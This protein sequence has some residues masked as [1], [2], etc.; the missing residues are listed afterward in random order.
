MQKKIKKE[1]KYTWITLGVSIV[2]VLFVIGRN[3]LIDIPDPPADTISHIVATVLL[4]ITIGIDILLKSG[5][6]NQKFKSVKY[7]GY[8]TYLVILGLLLI[9]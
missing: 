7:I 4:I 5:A 2:A 1:K 3:I 9:I 8:A 6:I